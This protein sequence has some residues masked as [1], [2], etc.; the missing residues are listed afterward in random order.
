MV[1]IKFIN[2]FLRFLGRILWDFIAAFLDLIVAFCV[3]ASI[4]FP[5]YYFGYWIGIPLTVILIAS[6]LF[7]GRKARQRRATYKI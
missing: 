2:V 4:I 5:S 7:L 1:L 3:L 6:I